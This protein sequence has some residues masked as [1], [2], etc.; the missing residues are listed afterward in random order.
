MKFAAVLAAAASLAAVSSALA[1]DPA[2][3][4]SGLQWLKAKDGRIVDE[5]GAPVI[6]RGMGLG[7]WMLQEGYMLRLSKLGQEHVIRGRIAAL[8]GPEREAAIHTAWLDNHTTKADID[9]MAAAGFNSVRLPMHYALLTLPADQEPAPG[10]DTWKD[11]GFRRIDELLAWTKA[12]GMHLILDLHAAPGGQGNDLAISDRDPEKPS[13]WESPENQRKTIALWRKLAERY[14]DEPAV[15]AYDVLNE[16]NWDFDGPATKNGCADEKQ[17]LLWDLQ[18]RIT[19]AIREVDQRHLVIIEG[20]CWGNNYKGMGKPW[21][22]NMALSFHK[23]WNRNDQASVEPILKLREETGLPVWLGESGENSNVWF[24]DAIRLVEG[25]GIGWAFWP[26]KKIG[27][28]QPLEITVGPDYD[29][30]AAALTGEAKTPVP[31]D[32]AYAVLMKLASHDVRFENNTS[33]PDVL[34]AMLRQPHDGSVRPFRP[35]RITARGGAIAAV[36]YDLGPIGK[37]YWDRDAA[38]YHVATGGERTLWNNGRTA[39]NDGVDIAP[40][41]KGV[42]DFTAGEWLRYT[43]TADRAGV[44]AV[45]IA[46]QGP[47]TVSANGGA[48]V[49]SGGTAALQGG[50]NSLILRSEGAA[51]VTSITL[52][53]TTPKPLP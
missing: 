53:P 12:A 9:Y 27:F 29:A 21:D 45:T 30:V 28:N 4:P 16:P 25:H 1:A 10:A 36:D 26:L 18:R 48:A 3:P 2:P 46:G 14:K 34:D 24:A 39:R 41:G 40:D 43:V 52:K 11:D 51:V 33:H 15:A 20:N 13:L 7:G 42:T 31:A 23:Y 38:N 50:T 17:D 49:R 6:L 8:V 5:T 47:M 37:A 44:Y 19:A 35:H 22:G 32:K